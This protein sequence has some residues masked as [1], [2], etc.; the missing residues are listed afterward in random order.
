MDDRVPRRSWLTPNQIVT[1]EMLKWAEKS[2]ELENLILLILWFLTIPQ[3]SSDSFLPIESTDSLAHDAA[4]DT[5]GVTIPAQHSDEAQ[6][7]HF[8]N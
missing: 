1:I 7:P 3:I 5:G 4:L 8:E 2:G 6:F